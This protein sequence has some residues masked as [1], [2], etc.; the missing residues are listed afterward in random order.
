MNFHL[1]QVDK[2]LG[3]F[4]VIIGVQLNPI[5]NQNWQ[6][7]KKKLNY[8]EELSVLAYYNSAYLVCLS[9]HSSIW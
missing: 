8:F 6:N 2:L 1:R 3:I 9:R 5:Y 4:A 7:L